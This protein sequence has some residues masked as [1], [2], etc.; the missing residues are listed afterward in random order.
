M[1]DEIKNIN[2]RQILD[3]R[4]N[5]TISVEIELNSGL[6]ASASV[7]SGA[8]TGINEAYELRDNEK[9]VYMGRGVLGAVKNVKEKIS[10]ALIGTSILEQRKIDEILIE[11]DGTQN[12]K[13]LGANAIL[14]VSLASARLASKFL[15]IPLYKYLG[16][17]NGN[18]L[19]TPMVN[20]LNGGVHADNNL[21]FQEFMITPTGFDSFHSGLRM[22]V[23]TFFSLKKILKK[24][25]MITSVGDEGGFAPNLN[26]AKEALDLTVEAINKAGY[27]TEDI[28]IC[29]DVASSEFYK[30]GFYEIKSENLKLNSLEMAKY[31][32][33]LVEDYPI[34]SIED[35]MAE[36]DFEGW[37]IITDNLS[38]KC[39]LVGD[40]LFTTNVKLLTDGIKNNLANAIL[41]KPNQIGTLTETLDCIKLAKMNGYKTIISHRSGETEDTFISDLAVGVNSG[42]IKT[43][44][45]TRSERNAKYNRLL[46]I[47]GELNKEFQG[48]RGDG[49]KYLGLGSYKK[50]YFKLNS[51]SN[52]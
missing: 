39:L 24:E 35:P 16:G 6:M 25:N 19:P 9:T 22:A 27:S 33:N 13:N 31:L 42:L 3:S 4:G 15:N 48:C 11:Q 5:P 20:I 34:I 21:E 52:Y 28:K 41:I 7:P 26:S 50:R 38:S 45:I 10:K 47:E 51:C 12:K 23:E 40:D 17:I 37:K 46:E 1:Q 8:S 18:I 30:D 29:L 49:A 43:G 32:Q 44:S 2:A 14:G 36:C